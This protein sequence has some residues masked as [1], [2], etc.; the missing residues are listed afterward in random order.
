MVAP[1]LVTGRT[2]SVYYKELADNVYRFAPYLFG[3]DELNQVHG[4]DERISV[5]SYLIMI[6]FYIRFI[7]NSASSMKE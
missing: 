5:D 3:P 4:L 7:Q 2:D 6:Q 1:G